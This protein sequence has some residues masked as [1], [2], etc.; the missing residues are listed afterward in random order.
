MDIRVFKLPLPGLGIESVN[1]YLVDNI[2]VDV[3]LYS[4]RT[5]HV[6]VR[7]LR[8]SGVNV[9]DAEGV[10]V[11]HFHVDHLSLLPLLLDMCGF[12]AHMGWRDVS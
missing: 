2:L 12:E 8:A 4:A 6:L 9:C 3:G 5:L 1:V 10:V 7:G 11:T